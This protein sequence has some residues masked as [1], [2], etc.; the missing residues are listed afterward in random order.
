MPGIELDLDTLSDGEVG[1]DGDIVDEF[2]GKSES[3]SVRRS[4]EREERRLE[5]VPP[6]DRR[7]GRVVDRRL[8][9]PVEQFETKRFRMILIL[10]TTQSV[11]L[12]AHRSVGKRT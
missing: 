7:F 12:L 11:S 2:E 1:R 10:S 5:F 8:D 3:K 6:F 4:S 9:P